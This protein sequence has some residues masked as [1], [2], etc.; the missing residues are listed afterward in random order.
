MIS[1]AIFGKNV[2]LSSLNFILSIRL[3][4]DSV[5]RRNNDGAISIL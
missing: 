1:F 5:D 4:D 2:T 3:H